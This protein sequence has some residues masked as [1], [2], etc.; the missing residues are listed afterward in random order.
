M[1]STLRIHRLQLALAALAVSGA[2]AYAGLNIIPVWDTTVTAAPNA[3]DYQAGFNYA[4]EQFTSRFAND[5][6]VRVK[7]VLG[8]TGGSSGA[9]FTTAYTYSEIRDA[10]IART[11]IAAAGL[12]VDDPVSEDHVYALTVANALALGLPNR[13]VDTKLTENDATL[14]GIITLEGND[15][16]RFDPA[17]PNPATAVGVDFVGTAEHEISEI[18]GRTQGNFPSELLP[19]DL[20]RFTAPGVRGLT[21]NEPGVY[22]SI[23]LGATKLKGFNQQGGDGDLQDWD[24][25]DLTDAFNA[26]SDGSTGTFMS[27]VDFT[28]ME[29]IGY[30]PMAPVTTSQPALRITASAGSLVLAWDAAAAGFTLESKSNLAGSTWTTVGTQNPTTE[31][32]G[33]ENRFYRL[34]K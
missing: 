1:T 24:S 13:D 9:A 30:T 12:P 18:L 20:Y 15:A 3:A 6:T 25:E 17:D 14:A 27:A 32:I 34:R 16:Y 21:P 11:S 4:I 10:L 28:A 2:Q 23:D 33:T 7:V 5:M 29:A 19:N 22:F 31:P 26:I 8:G